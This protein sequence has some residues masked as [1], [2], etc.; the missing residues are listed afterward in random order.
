VVDKFGGKLLVFHG[1]GDGT[2]QQGATVTTGAMRAQVAIA[3][4]DG[5]QHL[6]RDGHS[7]LVV[8]DTTGAELAILLGNG[9][10]TFQQR[11]SLALAGGPYRFAVGDWSGD[12][13]PD[14]AATTSVNGMASVSVLLN[15]TP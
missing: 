6:D 4:L 9:K 1:N 10:G 13:R 11:V 7:D 15:T 12:G 3:D 8:G 14:L 2:L 5:D